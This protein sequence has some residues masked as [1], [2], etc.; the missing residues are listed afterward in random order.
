LALQG[1]GGI[2]Q[3]PK[4]FMK[5]AYEMIRAKGGVCVADEVKLTFYLFSVTAPRRG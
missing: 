3:Y 4:D 2:V 5:N 1:G